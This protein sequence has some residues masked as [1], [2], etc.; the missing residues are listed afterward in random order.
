M[1]VIV[2]TVWMQNSRRKMEEEEEEGEG[3]GEYGAKWDATIN[4]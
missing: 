3:L 1:N 2:C 4:G